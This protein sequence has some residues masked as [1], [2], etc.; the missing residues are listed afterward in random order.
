MSCAERLWALGEERGQPGR[1]G[2]ERETKR[3]RVISP[4][5]ASFLFKHE[6]RALPLAPPFP[7]FYFPS[8]LAPSITY[9][10][11]LFS[12]SSPASPTVSIT[13]EQQER[14]EAAES[15]QPPEKELQLKDKSTLKLLRGP[16]GDTPCISGPILLC[17]LFHFSG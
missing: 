13:P 6:C 12:L 3:E 17:I 5:P 14:R 1:A 8:P 4:H 16:S 10:L 7:L 9:S 15:V 2:R 11:S